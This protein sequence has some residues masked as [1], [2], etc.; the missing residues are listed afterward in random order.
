MSLINIVV[1]RIHKCPCELAGMVF[2]SCSLLAANR[3]LWYFPRRQGRAARTSASWQWEA[4]P[5]LS[6]RR[7]QRATSPRTLRY[8]AGKGHQSPALT[9]GFIQV[10]ERRQKDVEH[11]AL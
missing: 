4:V 1:I 5:I 10:G 11:T 7:F 8:G 6:D 3:S 9:T 2:A